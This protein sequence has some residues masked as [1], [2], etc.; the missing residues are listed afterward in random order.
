MLSPPCLGCHSYSVPAYVQSHVDLI[1]PT[2][3]FNHRPNPH[4]VTKRTG[5]LGAPHL[6]NGPKKSS[7]QF[8]SVTP[9]LTN[10]DEAITL[11]CIRAL[12]AFEYTPQET[13]K[14]S[15]GIGG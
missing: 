11:D 3:H 10:C 12:Y 4:R 9:G 13:N 6:K 7:A 15:F 1:K 2:V 14:N 8:P 5:G